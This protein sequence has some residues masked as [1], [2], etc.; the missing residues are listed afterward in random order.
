MTALRLSGSVSVVEPELLKKGVL[1]NALD[2]LSILLG[3]AYAVGKL[4]RGIF[5]TQHVYGLGR[6]VAYF[7][8]KQVVHADWK[9]YD[10]HR[11][12]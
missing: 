8:V 4:L 1:N 5:G 3:I 9:D 12:S 10:R 11:P 6:H 2:A 7:C